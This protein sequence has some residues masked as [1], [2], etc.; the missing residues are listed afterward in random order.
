MQRT[1]L[2]SKI[3]GATVTE[4]ALIATLR[5]Q[6]AAFKTPKKIFLMPELPR[7]AMAKVQKAVLRQ[8]FGDTY[9]QPRA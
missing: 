2:K 9:T 6:L 4:A 8:Q 5:E 3:H 1:M 7:N